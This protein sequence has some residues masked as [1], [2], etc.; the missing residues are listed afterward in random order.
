MD[1]RDW[2]VL[3][4]Q[5]AGDAHEAEAA[6]WLS[7][8]HW[9]TRQ[10]V[11]RIE[12]A[13]RAGAL[14]GL[15]ARDEPGAVRGWTFYL[16]HEGVLQIG[17]F[18]ADSA[19][20]TA[21]LLDA[22]T[23]TPEAAAASA[24]MLFVFSDAP[25]LA[26]QLADRGFAIERYRYLEAGLTA[27]HGHPSRPFMPASWRA[28]ERNAVAALFERAYTRN[29]TARPFARGGTSR[30]WREYVTQLVTTRACGEFLADASFMAPSAPGADVAGATLVTRLSVDTAHV[31]QVAVAPEARRRGLARQL[32]SSSLDAAR[33]HACVRAT[34]LVS[35]GNAAAG[36]LYG[37]MGFK[38][39]AV[40]LSAA[41]NARCRPTS[42]PLA[43]G[44]AT[45]LT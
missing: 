2:R 44:A 28:A 21:T 32:L 43:S 25:G 31:A 39:V 42:D 26:A 1:A 16:V 15:V 10:S 18:V 27:E 13:R 8:L 12:A 3:T 9:D 17:A 14:A 41:R 45:T 38:E 35:E 34:L 24:V 29:E 5:E 36:R 22:V 7:R 11:V 33:R 19:D 23:R 37:T 6:R 4:E 40:F 20:A 30:E